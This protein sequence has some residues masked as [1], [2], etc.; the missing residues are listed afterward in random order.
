MLSQTCKQ[1]TCKGH[2][3]KESKAKRGKSILTRTAWGCGRLGRLPRPVPGRVPVLGRVPGP[4]PGAGE[5]CRR[6]AAASG[7]LRLAAAASR[8]ERAE[9]AGDVPL[10][11]LRV[12]SATG[13]GRK[14]RSPLE[15]LRG[16]VYFFIST[17]QKR[18]RRSR[19]LSGGRRG[20][21]F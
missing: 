7:R 12:L 13:Q 17:L 5:A 18:M 19:A 16:L 15:M 10:C 4:G 20:A 1:K 21:W 8:N 3:A 11:P 6:D 14:K 9:T 2:R